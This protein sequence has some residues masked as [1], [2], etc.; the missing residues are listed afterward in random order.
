LSVIYVIPYVSN[1]YVRCFNLIKLSYALAIVIRTK[2][3]KAIKLFFKS[4]NKNCKNPGLFDRV[5]NEMKEGGTKIP[6]NITEFDS[7]KNNIEEAIHQVVVPVEEQLELI[8]D[9]LVS[10]D[11]IKDRPEFGYRFFPNPHYTFDHLF[12]EF[13]EMF[14]ADHTGS[15]EMVSDRENLLKRMVSANHQLNQN[16]V[17]N[18]TFSAIILDHFKNCPPP[19]VFYTQLIVAN[20]SNSNY[21][22]SIGC[23]FEAF[24]F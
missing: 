22:K 13:C 15:A 11:Y 5:I 4:N 8:Q 21:F 18:K 3:S 10:M 1:T 14:L 23:N 17:Q 19:I 24:F 6:K 12:V 16:I 9:Y 7:Y 20:Y 2:D